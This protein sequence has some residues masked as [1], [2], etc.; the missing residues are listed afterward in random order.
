MFP[1][2]SA[3]QQTPMVNARFRRQE[4]TGVQRYADEICRR[5]AGELTEII[6]DP[7]CGSGLRGHWWEQT[8]LNRIA[9][10]QVLWSPCNTGPLRHRQ[11]VV[12]IHDMAVFDVPQGFTPTFRRLYQ[13][14]LPRLA[15]RAARVLTDSEF[16]KSRIV[17]LTKVSPDKVVVIPI[18]VSLKLHLGETAAETAPEL[19]HAHFVLAV[20][21]MTP[22]KNLA[23]LIAAWRL[24]RQRGDLEDVQLYIVGGESRNVFGKNTLSSQDGEGI[25]FLGRVDD[26]TL[27]TLYNRALCCV[28]PS[29]YEGFGLPIIEAFA[30]GCPV[31]CS[32]RTAFPEVGGDAV[33]YFDP[34]EPESIAESLRLAIQRYQHPLARQQQGEIVR[35]R[36][37]RFNWDRSAEQVRSVL[38]EVAAGT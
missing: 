20:G 7:S 21:S 32:D 34:A 25:Q 26:R 12:T 8:G 22:R 18:G 1:V 29:F 17:E 28:N 13:V 23:G 31:I 33:D 36:A 24:L 10:K 14:L 6:P 30:A 38:Q 4:M 11:H 37:S 27:A 35:L 15:R 5:L 19:A 3:S 16:S 2:P 9:R